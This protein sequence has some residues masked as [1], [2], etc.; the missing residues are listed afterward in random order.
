MLFFPKLNENSNA[1]SKYSFLS[2]SGILVYYELP[3]FIHISISVFFSFFIFGVSYYLAGRDPYYEKNSTYEC[4][5]SPFNYGS[6]NTSFDAHFY[7]ISILFLI[8][9]LEIIMVLPIAVCFSSADLTMLLTFYGFFLFLI[10]GFL[11][12]WFSGNLDF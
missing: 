6:D 9:D 10:L 12:E 4:G 11:Y 7:L 8:F 3:F 2:L 1:I 5:F